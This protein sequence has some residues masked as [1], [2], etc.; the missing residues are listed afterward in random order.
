MLLWCRFCAYFF[1]VNHKYV[2]CIFRHQKQINLDGTSE[3]A[4]TL[5]GHIHLD[6]VYWYMIY[7]DFFCIN[8]FCKKSMHDFFAGAFRK[9]K[10]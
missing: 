10:H 6:K 5:V 2:A 3:A 9:D 4:P 8:C 1:G 7:T